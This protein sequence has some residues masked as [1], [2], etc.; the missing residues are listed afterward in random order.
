MRVT[1]TAGACQRLLQ[2][3]GILAPV[4]ITADF[5]VF[6]WSGLS[7]FVPSRPRV[8]PDICATEM[9]FDGAN[10]YAFALETNSLALLTP[11][12]FQNQ[13]TK[14]D[15]EEHKERNSCPQH[16]LDPRITRDP[17]H[18]PCNTKQGELINRALRDLEPFD[19]TSLL[20]GGARLE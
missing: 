4:E 17:P 6:G 1:S 20:K 15:G 16:Q 13:L 3:L 19:L 12:Q 2:A 10:P 7:T 14:S 9:T 18:C 11:C 8:A 5:I